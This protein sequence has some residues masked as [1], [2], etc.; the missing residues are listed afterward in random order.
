MVS[1]DTRISGPSGN[2]RRS[3]PV[4]CSGE[5]FFFRSCSTLARSTGFVASFAGLRDELS[6]LIGRSPTD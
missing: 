4:I 3:R 5:Y 6:R 1:G 2:S